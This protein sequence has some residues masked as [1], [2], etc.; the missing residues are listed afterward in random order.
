MKLMKDIRNVLKNAPEGIR[1][2]FSESNMGQLNAEI[3]G[4]G[5]CGTSFHSAS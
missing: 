5:K 4:P 1:V 2:F 3:D